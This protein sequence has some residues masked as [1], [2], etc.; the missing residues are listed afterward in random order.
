[1]FV[2][3]LWLYD[4]AGER[5]VVTTRRGVPDTADAL[6]PYELHSLLR[7][8]MFDEHSRRELIRLQEQH[9]NLSAPEG[10]A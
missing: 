6:S 1:M 5:I 3:D 10:G 7:Q 8:L 2:H 9:H 4:F